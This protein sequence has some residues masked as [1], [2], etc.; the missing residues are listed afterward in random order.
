MSIIIVEGVD[1]VGKTTLCKKLENATGYKRFRDDFRYCS[2]YLD[3]NVN[4]EKI[5]TL[6]NLIE[7]WFVNDIILDRFHIT[8]YVYG[9]VDRGYANKDMIDIDERLSRLGNVLLVYVKPVD[10]EKSSKEHG[11]NLKEHEAMMQSFLRRTSLQNIQID[12][13]D[14]DL[15]VE[16][17][18]IWRNVK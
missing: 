13:N 7:N 12:Y 15:F 6:M 2:N 11:K 9:V 10:I 4:T 14:I 1:R 3:V 5:N 16:M 18:K 8:E 17:V